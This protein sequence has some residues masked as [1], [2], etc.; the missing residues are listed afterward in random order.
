MRL[1]LKGHIACVAA[2]LLLSTLSGC[3]ADDIIDTQKSSIVSFLGSK[4]YE[5]RGGAYCWTVN[6][7][8]VD[9]E[10]STIAATGDQITF[11]YVGYTFKSGSGLGTIFGTNIAA[12]AASLMAGMN[13]EY[14]TFGPTTTRVGSGEVVTGLDRAFKGARMGDSVQVFLTSDLCYDKKEMGI[15]PK[16][17]PTV[18]AVKI[19]DVTKQ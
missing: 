1:S 17:T 11:N 9:Y 18:F 7:S 2:L 10:T 12:V 4:T 13:T 16:N 15:L 5:I 6:S 3:G 8:R 14:W 19:I